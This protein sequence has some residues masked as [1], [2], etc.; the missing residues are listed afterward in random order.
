[1]NAL[2]KN[3]VKAEVF[4]EFL[5]QHTFAYEG[6]TLTLFREIKKN[7]YRIEGIQ[8]S[9]TTN[10][11]HLPY[12]FLRGKRCTIMEKNGL[13][14]LMILN[15]EIVRFQKLKTSGY[16]TKQW[17]HKIFG[18]RLLK[19]SFIQGRKLIT[20]IF[21]K[22]KRVGSVRMERIVK[23]IEVLR[24]EIIMNVFNDMK[25]ARNVSSYKATVRFKKLRRSKRICFPCFPEMNVKK[26]CILNETFCTPYFCN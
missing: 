17:K 5:P 7:R 20:I 22:D 13:D 12:Q 11:V 21:K 1:M 23:V 14:S 19:V 9:F 15:H 24:D 16:V 8:D 2:L 25:T 10:G 26:L 6:E 4:Y 3:G 18:W